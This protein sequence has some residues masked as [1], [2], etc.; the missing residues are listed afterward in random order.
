MLYALLIAALAWGGLG[1]FYLARV[2]QR[3]MERVTELL[4]GD[5]G[6]EWRSRM[7]DMEDAV[8]RLPRKWGEIVAEA[9]RSEERARYHVRTARKELEELGMESPGLE[10]VAGELRLLEGEDQGGDGVQ[11]LPPELEA[12]E[13]DAEEDWDAITYRRKYGA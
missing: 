13:Q 8:E 4:E 11:P 2:I 3:G 7:N 12:I 9:K 6:W 5:S 1:I 10:A